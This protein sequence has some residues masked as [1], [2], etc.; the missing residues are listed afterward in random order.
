M[1]KASFVRRG[2]TLVEMLVVITIIGILMALL[3]PAVQ[4]A[5]EA[6]R[7]LQCK[8]NVKQ[9][10]LALQNFHTLQKSFP[11][12][13]PTCMTYSSTNPNPNYQNVNGSTASTAKCTCCG[14]NW[15]IAILPQMEQL[16]TYN[17][18]LWC[19][20]NTSTQNVC[21]DC[22][23]PIAPATTANS[24]GVTWSGYGTII[25]PGYTCPSAPNNI[26]SV[27]AT[28]SVGGLPSNLAKGNYAG[29]WGSNTW[30]PMNSTHVSPVYSSNPSFTLY[31]YHG[32]FDIAQLNNSSTAPI[33]AGRARLGSN[34]GARIED[35]LDG[36]SN[37]AMVSELSAINSTAPSA[38]GDARG[39]WTWPMMGASYFSTA[40][41]PNSMQTDVLPLID[42]TSITNKDPMYVPAGAST[43]YTAWVA[44]A[45]SSHSSNFVNLGM[46]DGSVKQFND[47]IDP[48]VWC[49]MGTR[50]G[51]E[52]IQLPQ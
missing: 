27:N 4:A 2:F 32:M 28:G 10:C 14:P 25:P 43:T 26:T 23:L 30:V 48:T 34:Q 6:A 51:K 31:D 1:C 9:L 21:S 36:S 11:P 44:A 41:L 20:D 22:A 5:R 8:N 33:P 3:L 16:P 7:M 24:N 49:G 40:F 42:N 50:N 46:V 15:E 35:C 13:L 12:G 19:M 38:A 39:A 18:I 52:N 45:R 17:N 37:T 47:T 29:C